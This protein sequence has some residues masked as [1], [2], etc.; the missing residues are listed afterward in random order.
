MIFSPGMRI[1]VWVHDK[2]HPSLSGSHS[3][4][5][6]WQSRFVE[7]T[8][9]WRAKAIA[10]GSAC[11]DHIAVELQKNNMNIHFGPSWMDPFIKCF[12]Q[13]DLPSDKNEAKKI[14]TKVENYLYEDGVLI[15]R[16]KSTPWLKCVGQEEALVIIKETH[17]G[18]CATHEGA[19]T[20][21]NKI[22]R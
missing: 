16:E 9:S 14:S 20:L 10:L 1:A 4:Y 21:V 8:D 7:S 13:G 5:S 17:Q 6:E 19:S 15:K 22:F 2:E 11:E 3:T 18:V 12:D